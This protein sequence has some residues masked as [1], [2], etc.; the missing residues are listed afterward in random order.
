MGPDYHVLYQRHAYSVPHALVVS[1]IDSEAG[2]R[3]IRLHHREQKIA[4]HPEALKEGGFMPPDEHM[5][6]SHRHQRWSPERLLS[7]SESIGSATRTLIAWHL[8]ERK[9]PEQTYRSCL[10]LLSQIRNYGDA[11]L[12]TACHQVLLEGRTAGHRE[13]AGQPPQGRA[14]SPA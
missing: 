3:L 9:H 11:R 7:W 13:P 14:G 4:Q 12:E 6:D 10:C 5:P 1:H 8:H 2:P